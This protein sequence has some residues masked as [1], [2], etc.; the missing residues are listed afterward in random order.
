MN[1]LTEIKETFATE[2]Q[3]K[4]LF[5]NGIKETQIPARL[6]DL[7]KTLNEKLSNGKIR[8][9]K[10]AIVK[11]HTNQSVPPV[12]RP[13]RRIPFEGVCGSL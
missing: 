9:F 2:L 3:K 11:F 5:K 7:I 1:H 12:E 10:N 6:K 8:K 13:K 4:Q